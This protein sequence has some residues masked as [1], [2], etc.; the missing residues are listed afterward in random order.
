MLLNPIYRSFVKRL[1]RDR[2]P[3]RSLERPSK[4]DLDDGLDVLFKLIRTGMQWREVQPVSVSPITV[5]KHTRRWFEAGIFG[6]AYRRV[7]KV[8]AKH[9]PCKYYCMDSTMVKNIHGQDCVGRNPVDRGR[10]GTKISTTTDHNGVT[11]SLIATPA[12]IPD[13][14]LFQSVI[15]GHMVDIQRL[16]MFTDRGYNSR[17]NT[18]YCHRKGLKDRISRRGSKTTRRSNSKRVV[19]ECSYSWIDKHRRLI[20]RYEQDVNVY[21]E[22]TFLAMANMILKRFNVSEKELMPFCP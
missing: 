14:S 4:L 13:V 20:L 21:I 19:I 22:M 7:L 12:N 9:H 18:S 11:Y 8:Y 1:I 2:F 15:E 6:D 5:Y 3:P 10:R 16:E 17:K